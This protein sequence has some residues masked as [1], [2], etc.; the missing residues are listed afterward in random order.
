MR[1]I[2]VQSTRILSQ[3]IFY[4]STD[5]LSPQFTVN[6]V[7]CNIDSKEL[8]LKINNSQIMSNHHHTWTLDDNKLVQ[9]SSATETSACY[10]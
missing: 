4:C 2:C 5:P 3:L 1:Y 10:P 6:S 7:D 9:R 8:K